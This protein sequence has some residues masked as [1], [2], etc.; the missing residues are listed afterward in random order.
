MVQIILP[1]H[2]RTLAGVSGEVW[3][4][5]APPVTV[6]AI[7]DAVE[8]RFPPLLGTIRDAQSRKRRPFVRFYACE[9]DLSH[10]DPDT[11]LPAAVAEGREPFWI[12]GAIAGG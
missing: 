5:L 10:D 8:A 4:E 9:E 2:L 12:I 3:L 6:A 1:A 11:P 7:L